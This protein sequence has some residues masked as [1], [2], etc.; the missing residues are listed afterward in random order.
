MLLIIVVALVSVLVTFA[1]IIVS[2]RRLTPVMCDAE[3]LA[4]IAE[5]VALIAC[6]TGG[7]VTKGNA[8]TL[9]QNGAIF[10][11]MLEAIEAATEHVHLETFVWMK[12]ELEQRFVTALA[13]KA[14]AGVSVRVLLDAMGAQEA[15]P[16]QLQRLTDA[17]VELGHYC[18]PRWW[19]LRRMNHRTHRKLLIIDGHLGFAFGHGVADQWLG[20]A[21]DADHWRDT[22]VRLRGPVVQALQQVF[23][24]NWLEETQKLPPHINCEPSEAAGEVGAHVV[25]SA[26]GDAVSSVALLYSLAMGTARQRVTVQ[27]PYFAPERDMVALLCRLAQQGVRVELMVPGACTDS[28]MV[29]RAGQALYRSLLEAGVHLYE[30][31]RTLSHQKVVIVD[32]IWSHVGSTNMDARALALNEEVGV[33]LVSAE[34]AQQ[35]TEAF[36]RDLQH[37][38]K[39]ELQT[40]QQRPLTAKLAEQWAYFLR[41]Q[42]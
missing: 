41:G 18:K 1:Y 30:Y 17:G 16:Q 3:E 26:T 40:W 27:N 23:L 9:Y 11:A 6:A 10:P 34:C 15:D 20:D 21:E 32:G 35:L 28:P 4:P 22:G 31:E 29:R 33:G 8:A 42:I 2:R 36:E 13:A 14:R 38:S 25:S 12:G 5:S 24:E 37:A 39:L 7:V 19:N